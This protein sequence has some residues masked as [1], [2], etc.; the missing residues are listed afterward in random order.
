MASIPCGFSI[1]YSGI[2]PIDN[3]INKIIDIA[4]FF[5]KNKLY[6]LP[7]FNDANT[8]SQKRNVKRK[9]LK[10]CV[11]SELG[12]DEIGWIHVRVR[13]PTKN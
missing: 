12:A 5:L 13:F 11:F 7:T 4:L 2:H 8:T 10:L 1:I 6:V 9:K 3:S